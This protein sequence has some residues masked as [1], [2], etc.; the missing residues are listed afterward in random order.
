[1]SDQAQPTNLTA[2]QMTAIQNK[3]IAEFQRTVDDVEKRKEAMTMA[4]QLTEFQLRADP[5][6]TINPVD[7]ART[8]HEFM[9]QPAAE[10][11]VTVS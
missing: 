5:Y 1:M 4:V 2:A 9:M 3:M 8:I 7:L 6:A 11:K 10:I